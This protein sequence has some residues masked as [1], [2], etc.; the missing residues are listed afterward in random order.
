MITKFYLIA[1]LVLK[2]A[3]ATASSAAVCDNGLAPGDVIITAFNTEFTVDDSKPV[4]VMTTM[5]FL[6][7]GSQLYLSDRPLQCPAGGN[8]ACDFLPLDQT[9]NDG[10][11]KFTAY[12]D[13]PAG[14]T[15]AFSKYRKPYSAD[16]VY[17][18]EGFGRGYAD[19]WTGVTWT[20]PLLDKD[21]QLNLWSKSRTVDFSPNQILTGDNLHVYCLAGSSKVFLF[22]LLYSDNPKADFVKNGGDLHQ[23]MGAA[24]QVASLNTMAPPNSPSLLLTPSTIPNTIPENDVSCTCDGIGNGI[25]FNTYT[26]EDGTKGQCRAEEMCNAESFA[27][28][29]PRD[30]C[31]SAENIAA[32]W[33]DRNHWRLVRPDCGLTKQEYIAYASNPANWI[34][35]KDHSQM[36]RITSFAVTDPY[37]PGYCAPYTAVVAPDLSVQFTEQI[38]IE[39]ALVRS[40]ENR[41]SAQTTAAV[42]AEFIRQDQ[43]KIKDFIQ[44]G[45]RFFPDGKTRVPGNEF[46]G[47]Q[48]IDPRLPGCFGM[49]NCPDGKPIGVLKDQAAAFEKKMKHK[50]DIPPKKN[51]NKHENPFESSTPT[52]SPTKAPEGEL[53]GPRIIG[54]YRDSSNHALPNWKG[55]GFTI[56]ECEQLCKTDHYKFSGLQWMGDCYCGHHGYDKYGKLDDSA[57]DCHGPNVGGWRFCASYLLDGKVPGN[58]IIKDSRLT[59]EGALDLL[60]SAG[61]DSQTEFPP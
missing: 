57:C 22:S 40:S 38:R 4:V 3:L 41:V 36:P 8:G 52:R 31:G 60:V 9:L 33:E 48:A 6:A 58:E 23:G 17:F 61:G 39:E 15:I 30:G 16:N 37:E 45:S 5:K 56:S 13:I 1:T 19:D 26:C 49:P 11:A 25:P 42:S 24:S 51:D 27:R 32:N 20:D 21:K 29:L 18:Y 2:A 59:D 35:T 7:Q 14:S 54:C 28:S 55:S 47:T 53:I 46:P 10:T 34:Y 12:K 44:R 43:K 50:E